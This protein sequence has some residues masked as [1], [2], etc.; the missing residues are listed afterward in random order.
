MK[1]PRVAGDGALLGGDVR[2][3]R[4]HV[5]CVRGHYKW[6]RVDLTPS[7]AH[8]PPNPSPYRPPAPEPPAQARSTVLAPPPGP[9]LVSRYWARIRAT[10]LFHNHVPDVPLVVCERSP[11]SEDSLLVR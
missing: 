7:P 6:G 11:L 8:R 1:T 4:L 2:V 3:R 9:V 10:P 5:R